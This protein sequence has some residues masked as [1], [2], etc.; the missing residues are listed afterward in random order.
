MWTPVALKDGSRWPQGLGWRVGDRRAHRIVSHGGITGVNYVKLPDDG[1]TVITL[2]NLGNLTADVNPDINYY[3]GGSLPGDS[4]P[5]SSPQPQ[6]MSQTRPPS[7]PSDTSR[8]F[9]SS[10]EAKSR[11]ISRPP[12]PPC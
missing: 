4:C 10:P 1:V 12:S 6:P 2:G 7:V 8:H 5:G 3:R 11:P 9:A